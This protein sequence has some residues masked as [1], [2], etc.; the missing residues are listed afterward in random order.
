MVALDSVREVRPGGREVA[1]FQGIGPQIVEFTPA[2]LEKL[3][4]IE[5]AHAE[6]AATDL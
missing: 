6:R 1:G 4:Q 3:D 2:V 5:I